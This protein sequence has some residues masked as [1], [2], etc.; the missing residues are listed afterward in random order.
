MLKYFWNRKLALYNTTG[1][2]EERNCRVEGSSCE[3]NI[4]VCHPQILTI[5]TKG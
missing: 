2:V 3:I 1:T 4:S 5:Q